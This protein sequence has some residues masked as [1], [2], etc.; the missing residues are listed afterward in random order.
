MSTAKPTTR[1]KKLELPNVDQLPDL[2]NDSENEKKKESG[3]KS[4]V[5]RVLVV[6]IGMYVAIVSY[7]IGGA[8]LFR[9]LELQSYTE[10]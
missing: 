2:E 4:S 10:R 3:K 5:K 7:I 6:H 1:A 9:M 8:Y